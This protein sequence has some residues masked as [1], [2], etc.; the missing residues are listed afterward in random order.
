MD[1]CKPDIFPH[2]FPQTFFD[3]V[4]AITETNAALARIA[5]IAAIRSPAETGK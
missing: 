2:I 4:K 5:G 1:C 3:R